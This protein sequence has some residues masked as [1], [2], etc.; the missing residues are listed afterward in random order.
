MQLTGAVHVCL[1]I[2]VLLS[3]PVEPK[4]KIGSIRTH[5]SPA[6]LPLFQFFLRKIVSCVE[7]MQRQYF[8]PVIVNGTLRYDYVNPLDQLL[9]IVGG[10]KWWGYTDSNCGPLQCECSALTN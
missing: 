3:N 9:R 5:P 6:A 10:Q 1:K 7:Q 2:S 4:L 8:N